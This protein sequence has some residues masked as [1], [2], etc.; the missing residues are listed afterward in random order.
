M[1][2]APLLRGTLDAARDATDRVGTRSPPPDNSVKPVYFNSVHTDKTSRPALARL[3]LQQAA[4][5]Q[6]L[7]RRRKARSTARTRTRVADSIFVGKRLSTA[8]TR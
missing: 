6:N 7:T 3:A 4:I 1:E 5:K 2:E 8:A